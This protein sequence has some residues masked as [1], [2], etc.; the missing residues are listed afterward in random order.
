MPTFTQ[1]QLKRHK[2]TKT[3]LILCGSKF[4]VIMDTTK[5]HAQWYQKTLASYIYINSYLRATQ[6]T[7]VKSAKFF[8]ISRER[9]LD[10]KLFWRK[11]LLLAP[12]RKNK[13]YQNK[14]FICSLLFSKNIWQATDFR[15][16][17]QSTGRRHFSA[18]HR[19]E[20]R[21]NRQVPNDLL[22]LTSRHLDV[23][24]GNKQ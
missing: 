1:V 6:Q 5:L 7:H 19:A 8:S 22:P 2:L 17:P 20:D 21:Q 13:S 3:I 16:I 12:K 23:P 15:H 9:D 4:S 18:E 24:C 14:T 10:R 11:T